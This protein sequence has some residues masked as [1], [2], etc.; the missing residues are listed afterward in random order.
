MLS[1]SS[2]LII[3]THSLFTCV[4]Q[5][6]LAHL[7]LVQNAAARLLKKTYSALTHH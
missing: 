1:F 5:Q 4:L 7:Q 2:V 6:A 3:A